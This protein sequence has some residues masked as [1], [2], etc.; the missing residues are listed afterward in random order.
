MIK[1]NV[2]FIQPDLSNKAYTSYH[3]LKKTCIRLGNNLCSVLLFV[4]VFDD[5]FWFFWF[6]CVKAYQYQFRLMRFECPSYRLL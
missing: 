3:Q 5:L 1:L 6:F 2:K 4:S